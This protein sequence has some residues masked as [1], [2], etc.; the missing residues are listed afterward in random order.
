MNATYVISRND[1]KK[2]DFKAALHST[3]GQRP[4]KYEYPISLKK[5][6]LKILA[7]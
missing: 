7:Q 2:R 1:L 3:A 6:L 4:A 5:L